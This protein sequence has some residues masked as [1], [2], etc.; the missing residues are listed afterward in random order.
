MSVKAALAPWLPWIAIGAAAAL[1]GGG[2]GVSG[3]VS[4]ERQTVVEIGALTTARTT[5]G[6]T[7]PGG[8]AT[9]QLDRGAR[10]LALARND[11]ASWVSVRDPRSTASIVWVPVSRIEVDDDQG[12][13]G[14]LP[15]GDPCPAVSLPPLD[16]VDAP[17]VPE[18]PAPGP[19]PAAPAPVADTTKPTLSG[20]A[21]TP[22]HVGCGVST[23]LS[24][25]AADNVGV[26]GGSVTI[27][28]PNAQT[29]PLTLSGGVWQ[30][31]YTPTNGIYQ[32]ITATF[33]AVDAAG[34]VSA[35]AA[36]TVYLECLI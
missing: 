32:N 14:D 5:P 4:H 13:V 36:I 20:A 1:V 22:A 28:G 10:V 26:A 7:C 12:A 3:V 31:T 11:D 24:V 9:A 35:P 21:A 6:Y 17:V 27:T 2:L 19:A 16:V 25:N 18:A 8:G 30:W 23:I 33:T 34:N 15:L 29:K